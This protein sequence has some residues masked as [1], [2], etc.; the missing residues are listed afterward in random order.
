MPDFDA[1]VAEQ[2]AGRMIGV[3][4]DAS[5]ALMIS[6]GHQVGLFDVMAGL[7]PATSHEI[8]TAADL[9][10]R[11]VREWLG[12]MTTGRVV[13]HD[14]A[15]RTGCRPSMPPPSLVPRARTTLAI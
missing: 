6:I 9:Q 14:R 7:A 4:S 11:Y 10:E 8:A 3:L 13:C 12:A 15:Q 2:F 1:T 5:V